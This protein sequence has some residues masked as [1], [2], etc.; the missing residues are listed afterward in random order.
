MS[1][2]DEYL[3]EPFDEAAHADFEREQC[4][5][6]GIEVGARDKF[7]SAKKRWQSV[8]DIIEGDLARTKKLAKFGASGRDQELAQNLYESLRDGWRASDLCIAL[9]LGENA[10]CADDYLEAAARLVA[11]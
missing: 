5:L 8:I 2:V 3:D 10:K 11:A 1:I 6:R 9:T 7:N 4:R